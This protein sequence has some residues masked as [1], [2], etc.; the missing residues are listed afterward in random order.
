VKRAPQMALL[1]RR[2]SLPGTSSRT[3]GSAAW[4]SSDRLSTLRV[5]AMAQA[6]LRPQGTAVLILAVLVIGLATVWLRIIFVTHSFE[7]HVDEAIYF[8]ISQNFAHH[9]RLNYDLGGRGPFFLHPPLFFFIEAAYVKIASPTG[10]VVQQVIAVRNVNALFGGC[11]GALVFILSRR[12]AGWIPGLGAAAIFALEPFVIRMDSRNFLEPS[13]MLWVLLGLCLV[14]SGAASRTESRRSAWTALLQHGRAAGAGAAFAAALL[15]NE[16]VAFITLVP[17]IV[18]AGFRFIERREATVTAIS[19]VSLYSIYPI[20]TALTGHFDDFRAQKLS[21]VGRFVGLT[22]VTGFN[23]RSGPSFLTA[24]L[25]HWETLAPTYLLLA[26]G[27]VA[28]LVLAFRGG[29]SGRLVACWSGSAY[30]LQGYSILFGTNEEQYFYYVV[31]LAI[32]SSVVA[33]RLIVLARPAASLNT[34]HERALAALAGTFVVMLGVASYL[35]L[36]RYVMAPRVYGATGSAGVDNANTVIRDDALSY[37]LVLLAVVPLVVAL[38]AIAATGPLRKPIA[39]RSQARRRTRD[40]AVAFA[41]LAVLLGLS[42]VVAVHRY[43]TPDDGYRHLVQY[44]AGYVPPGS[45]VAATSATDA[46][47]LRM[48][49]YTVTDSELATSDRPKAA[50]P[51]DP[52]ALTKEKPE[53][54]TVATQLVSDNYG[55]GTPELLDWLDQHG[56]LVFE[57]A[58]PSDGRLRVYRLPARPAT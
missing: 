8:R 36:H 12:L 49:G 38:R 29:K 42:G 33:A 24:A 11:S 43:E 21:G 20:I 47:V 27:M 56:E 44:F 10:S 54:L 1:M 39:V 50:R 53:Y 26:M 4:F 15:T 41:L 13:A 37:Y 40:T 3:R 35:V 18:C 34:V 7:I 32:P 2:P 6:V 16:P 25:A 52:Y 58:G 19:A 30:L 17:V 55:I 9:L 28:T 57:F 48:A 5:R 22:V 23:S 45:R 14:V 51:R 46:T 31:V